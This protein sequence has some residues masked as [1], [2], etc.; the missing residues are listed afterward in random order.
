MNMQKRIKD[1]EYEIL[2]NVD[3]FIEVLK[4]ADHEDLVD[5][6]TALCE[7]VTSNIPDWDLQHAGSIRAEMKHFVHKVAMEVI[8][9]EDE[10]ND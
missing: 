3:N 1:E 9:Y 8:N 7:L 5:L 2:D 4:V 6:A 10:I